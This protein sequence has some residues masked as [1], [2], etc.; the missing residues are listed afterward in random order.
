MC[1]RNIGDDLFSLTAGRVLAFRGRHG[2]VVDQSK[3][4]EVFEKEN[5]VKEGKWRKCLCWKRRSCFC[6][7]YE[8]IF[9]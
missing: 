5:T 8:G 2:A 6:L 3:W 9:S 4:M 7:E 1:G